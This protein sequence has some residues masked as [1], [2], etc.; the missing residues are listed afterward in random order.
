MPGWTRRLSGSQIHAARVQAALEDAD[1]L[2]RQDQRQDQLEHQ[3]QQP[4]SN[5]SVPAAAGQQQ[6]EQ[7][8][9]LLAQQ[10]ARAEAALRRFVVL[11][12]LWFDARCKEYAREVSSLGAFPAAAAT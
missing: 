1:R 7:A 10:V 6:Q 2:I 9:L 3:Q 8:R 11:Q 12:W 5:G 4:S